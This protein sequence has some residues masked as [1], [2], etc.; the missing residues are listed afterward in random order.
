MP[1]RVRAVV[2]IHTLTHRERETLLSSYYI[3]CLHATVWTDDSGEKEKNKH[4]N[5]ERPFV[6]HIFDTFFAVDPFLSFYASKRRRFSH[7]N[8]HTSKQ[9]YTSARIKKTKI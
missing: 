3:I 6:F 1:F 4:L 5:R 8:V 2:V 7:L 9:K